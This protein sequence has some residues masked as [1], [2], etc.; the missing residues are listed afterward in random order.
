M[1]I[2]GSEPEERGFSDELLANCLIGLRLKHNK[3]GAGGPC[4][5]RSLAGDLF[6]ALVGFEHIFDVSLEQQEVRR[7][8][9]VDLQSAAIIPRSE[10]R[11]VGKECRL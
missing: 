8:F 2:R 5:G 1:A 9:A 6:D 11:R 10:E 4:R 7:V 3:D